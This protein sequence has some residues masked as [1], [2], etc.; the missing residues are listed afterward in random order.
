MK[1]I[2]NQ[3]RKLLFIAVAFTVTSQFIC[4]QEIRLPPTV[5]ASAGNSQTNNKVNISKWRL[6]QVHVV[7]LNRQDEEFP[8]DWHFSIYPNPVSADLH[9]KFEIESQK[10]LRYEVYNVS[11]EKILHKDFYSVFPGENTQIDVSGFRSGLYL[12]YI[13]PEGNENPRAVKF[14][15]Q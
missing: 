4:A 6:G 11:G 13:I 9:I 5:V 14:E 10:S 3:M 7:A 8:V 1:P 15:K 12:L 2:R